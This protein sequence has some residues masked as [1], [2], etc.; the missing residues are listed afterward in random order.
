MV[1]LK[2]ST[3]PVLATPT[4]ADLFPTVSG[5]VTSSVTRA[6]T[7]ALGVGEILTLTGASVKVLDAGGTDS[8][9]F[10]HDGTNFN[11]A[12]TTTTDWNVTGLTGAAIFASGLRNN[13]EHVILSNSPNLSANH[14]SL[15]RFSN[16]LN[17]ISI[18]FIGFDAYNGLEIKNQVP[19]GPLLMSR[20]SSIGN[21]AYILEASD[22]YVSFGHPSVSVPRFGWKEDFGEVFIISSWTPAL[23]FDTTATPTGGLRLKNGGSVLNSTFGADFGMF[24]TN[25]LHIKN[26]MRSGV[27]DITG[28]DAAGGAA[29]MATFSPV[30]S[31]DLS[32]ANVVV[33]KTKTAATGGLE[34]NNTQTGAGF[35]RVLTQSDSSRT[36]TTAELVAIAN[37]I[38]TAAEKEAGFMVFNTTTSK[39]VWAVGNTNGAVWVDAT[40]ATA[41]TP[42]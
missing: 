27:F 30:A 26:Y 3:L 19:A 33:V 22:T 29:T 20:V 7:H 6:K 4:A 13:L 9:D 10:S 17:T 40:G 12:F 15:V 5:G 31:A 28:T 24:G 38:N 21:T 2:I 14:N 1:D 41:H 42:A 36:S 11:T 32:Y 8:A 39:P 18:G 34:A 35:E 37:A 25:R 16:S 23:P